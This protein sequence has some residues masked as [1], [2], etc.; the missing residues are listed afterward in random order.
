MAVARRGRRRDDDLLG[1]PGT[2]PLGRAPGDGRERPEPRSAQFPL[3]AASVSLAMVAGFLSLI[4]GGAVVR[5]LVLAELMA[6]RFGDVSRSSV[7]CCCVWSG[8]SPNWSFPLSCTS[9]GPD[10]QIFFSVAGKI[11]VSST[12]RACRCFPSSFPSTTKPKA[13]RRCTPNWP[14][15]P[16][17][18][19]RAGHHLRRRRLARRLL[20]DHPPAGRGATRA[21]AASASAGTSARRRP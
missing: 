16:G 19:L 7:P 12:L 4:P 9:F 2:E 21:S 14:K 6:P 1:T 10:G 3:Y 8:W 20:G 5:E 11:V 15:W 17:R 13:S 18:R